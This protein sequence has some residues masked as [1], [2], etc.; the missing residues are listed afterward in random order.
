MS[1]SS[2][3]L[4]HLYVPFQNEEWPLNIFQEI[5][6]L[7]FF[8]NSQCANVCVK[9]G[10]V[11][12]SLPFQCFRNSSGSG[13]LVSRGR[14]LRGLVPRDHSSRLHRRISGG[15]QA[16]SVGSSRDLRR[17][18]HPS[19]SVAVLIAPLRFV[20]TAGSAG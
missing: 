6:F 12:F 15:S 9:A 5:T 7:S 16:I 2:F 8:P 20:F 19:S 14:I 1:N 18:G 10:L 17:S 11:V 13:I 4:F 3:L